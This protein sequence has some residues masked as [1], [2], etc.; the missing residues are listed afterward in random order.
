MEGEEQEE[1][2]NVAA[3]PDPASD[4]SGTSFGTR[5]GATRFYE[6]I[7]CKRGFSTAQALGGH[8]NIH[9]RDRAKIRP[10]CSSPPDPRRAEEAYHPYS[11]EQRRTQ[12]QAV[13][14][15]SSS[16]YVVY[17]PGSSSASDCGD[18]TELVLAG[19]ELKLCLSG[20]GQEIRKEKGKDQVVSEDL[21]LEL[22]LGH[23]REQESS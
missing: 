4:D 17:F 3:P 21:D 18:K 13:E 1:H 19:E 7:F 15:A 2:L 11:R 8:M 23:S 12:P 5:G 14:S 6:C 22:R 10:S 20:P 16:N 9:R